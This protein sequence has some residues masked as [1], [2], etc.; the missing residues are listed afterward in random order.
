MEK[1]IL[2]FLISKQDVLAGDILLVLRP[3]A[4][5]FILNMNSLPTSDC[6]IAIEQA[7]QLW[8]VQLTERPES[9][10]SDYISGSCTEGTAIPSDPQP[11]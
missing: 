3:V 5:N 7:G 4:S 11:L 6:L 2:K 10:E 9:V 1:L 8:S